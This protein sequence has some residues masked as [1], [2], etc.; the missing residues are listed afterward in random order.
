MRFLSWH[1]CLDG[2][3]RHLRIV[4]FMSAATLGQQEDL[5]ATETGYGIAADRDPTPGY[6]KRPARS[7]QSSKAMSER[8]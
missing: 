2:K 3:P 7:E 4:S 5:L 8:P 1:H 6:V